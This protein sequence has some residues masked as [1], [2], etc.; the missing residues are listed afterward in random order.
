MDHLMAEGGAVFWADLF[1]SVTIILGGITTALAAAEARLYWVRYRSPRDPW[2]RNRRL[3]HMAT[4]RAGIAVACLA[5]S[6]MIS[7]YVGEGSI[8]WRTP[9]ALV[10]FTILTVGMVNI[11]RN[12]ETVI[13]HGRVAETDAN[14]P[15]APPAGKRVR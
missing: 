9:A 11:L 4:I 5:L 14:E 13:E 2:Y 1:R 3:V 15:G 6:A 12:D 10:A 7:A 8:T